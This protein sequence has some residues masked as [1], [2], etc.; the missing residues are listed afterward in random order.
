MGL[1]SFL[2]FFLSFFLS[3]FLSFFLSFFLPFLQFIGF[4]LTCCHFL[5][6]TITI[7]KYCITF[8]IY[9]LSWSMPCQSILILK[10]CLITLN[11][12]V[13]MLITPNPYS[14]TFL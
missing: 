10:P 13:L 14:L 8:L 3:L 12:L 11:I 1:S 9:H 7:N 6:I 2:S 5:Y 4:Y